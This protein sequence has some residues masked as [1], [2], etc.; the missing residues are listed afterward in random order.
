M[1]KFKHLNE[2]ERYQIQYG[3]DQRKSFK[4]IARDLGR[5]CTTI[6]KEIRSRMAFK[7]TGSL[8]NAFNDC[9][10]RI[11]CL[12]NGVCDNNIDCR[13]KLCRNCTQTK[14]FKFCKNYTKEVCR[15][16]DSVP[17][18]CNGCDK[19]NRCTLEKAFYYARAAQI[20][21]KTVLTE[22]RCGI[23][24]DD[25]EIKRLDEYISPLLKN[26]Q[27][28]HHILSNS[29]GKIMWSEKTIYKYVNNSLFSARNIDLRRK[30]RFRPRKSNHESLKIN[31]ACFNERTYKDY[32]K[33]INDNP[34][35]HTVEMDTVHGKPGGKCLLTLHFVDANYMLAY[36][37]DDCTADSVKNAFAELR[38]TLGT[39]LYS[40]LFPV[41]LG[42]RGSEFTDPRSIE[43]DEE[44]ELLSSVY[45]CDPRQSQQKGSL[46]R[47]HEFI[48]YISPK[49]VSMD[50]YTQDDIS[51][52][53]NH[54]NSYGRPELRNRT[55][56][57]MFEF[58]YEKD[59][60]EALNKVGAILVPADKIILR[61]SLIKK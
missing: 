61:P 38:R 14:C 4:Q 59:G 58:L 15:R 7:Q 48:R 22:S 19:K 49:G 1:S 36:L 5:D 26:G 25:N 18:V 44:G 37:M 20:E 40:R 6:S 8:G 54:I 35:I 10:H 41:L 12:E 45:Y 13:K 31:R 60:R 29:A 33:Y 16:R 42:D 46:E 2:E 32:N 28:I 11:G 57:H 39:E 50:P 3:L 53:M 34:S 47:N 52:M 43:I 55:P 9:A 23:C 51:L 56:Y 17:Y 27:S 30:L 21:Y 24:A